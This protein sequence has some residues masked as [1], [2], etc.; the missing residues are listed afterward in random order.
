MKEKLKAIHREVSNCKRCR[1]ILRSKRN[2]PRSGFPPEDYYD[3]VI[4]GAEPGARGVDRPSPI[5]YKDRFDPHAR[6]RN[7]IRLVFRDL[8]E[9]GLDW[10]R[11]F[12]TNSVKCA[13]KPRDSLECFAK[14]RSFLEKQVR[15]L[16]P[17]VVVTLGRASNHLGLPKPGLK[18]PRRCS[19]LEFPAIAARHPQGA[20]LN[21]RKKLARLICDQLR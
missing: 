3:A 20:P 17:Q 6:N 15:V 12:Y 2:K 14:C 5:E 1:S 4:I 10:H 9:E 21:Y 8:E 19:Y 16:R 7:T 13:A 11:F 18:A